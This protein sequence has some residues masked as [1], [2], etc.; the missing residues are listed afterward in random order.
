MRITATFR[1]GTVVTRESETA[2]S[3]ASRRQHERRV[4]FH[5][6]EEAARR[7]AGPFGE[8]TPVDGS[9]AVS[10]AACIVCEGAGTFSVGPSA[11]DGTFSTVTCHRCGGSG[12]RPA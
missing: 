3:H 5:K 9:K 10:G 7:S 2:Y 4:R 1:D 11:V 12:K 6:S 8:I